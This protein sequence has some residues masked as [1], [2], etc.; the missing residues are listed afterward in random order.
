MLPVAHTVV[1]DIFTPEE[2]ARVQ[3]YIATVWATSAV[4]GPALGAVIVAGL[5][6]RWVFWINLP[7]GAVALAMLH[8]YYRESIARRRH[9]I[10]FAGAALLIVGGGAIMLALVQAAVYPAALL[11]GL[12]A[13]AGLCAALLWRVERRVPE[14]ILPPSLWRIPVVRTATLGTVVVG[15]LMMGVVTYLPVHIQGA[16][17]RDAETVAVAL[18]LMAVAWSACAGLGGRLRSAPATGWWSASAAPS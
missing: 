13:V 16:L 9:R 15:A 7:L 8:A 14:P 12:V 17:G 2:R 5:D 18:A 3:G 1:G 10:D 6:W 11:A 4:V